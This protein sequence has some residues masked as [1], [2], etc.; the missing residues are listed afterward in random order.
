MTGRKCV[1]F[2]TQ[3]WRCRKPT[4]PDSPAVLQHSL[5][6]VETLANTCRHTVYVMSRIASLQTPSDPVIDATTHITRFLPPAETALIQLP[7]AAA[8]YPLLACLPFAAR[9]QPHQDMK[10]QQGVV[11]VR[12]ASLVGHLSVD[13][14]VHLAASAHLLTEAIDPTCRQ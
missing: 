2:D 6:A 5:S 10:G 13:V 12:V 1:V 4:N 14:C 3:L 9:W 11:L 8:A 7:P